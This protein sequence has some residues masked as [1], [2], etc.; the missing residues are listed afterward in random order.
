[1]QLKGL[2]ELLGPQVEVI[3]E[4]TVVLLILHILHNLDLDTPQEATLVAILL[5]IH[6]LVPKA[7]IQGD[8]E[9]IQ[10]IKEGIQLK[11]EDI[12]VELEGILQMLEDILPMLAVTLEEILVTQGV[13][14]ETLED[15]LVTLEDIHLIPEVK[16]ASLVE[17]QCFLQAI[18]LLDQGLG[19]S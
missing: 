8:K 16:E 19:D 11:L 10:A 17:I 18:C 13:T 4:V 6:I 14:L 2:L 1:M 5:R 12:L 15:T 3:K 9:V 7:V